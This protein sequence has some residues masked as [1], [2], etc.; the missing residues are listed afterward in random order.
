MAIF[1]DFVGLNTLIYD[2]IDPD[3][4]GSMAKTSAGDYNHAGYDFTASAPSVDFGELNLYVNPSIG[5]QPSASLNHPSPFLNTKTI[6]PTTFTALN[7]HRNGPYGWPTWKQIRGYEKPLV[8]HQ[9][10][11]NTFTSN[12][13][14]C[15]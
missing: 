4:S 2:P 1:L 8:R 3:E 6:T 9:I 11:N 15:Y 10:L 13:I 12:K 14:I 5:L 7:I